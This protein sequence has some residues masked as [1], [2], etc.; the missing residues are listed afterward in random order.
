MTEIGISEYVGMSGALGIIAKLFVILYFS[1]K[2]NAVPIS[3]YR[4]KS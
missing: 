1:K 4:N 3:K 2:A